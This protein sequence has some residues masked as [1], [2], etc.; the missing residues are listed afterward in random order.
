M[1]K[2]LVS[3]LTLLVCFALA[4]PA[5]AQ[6]ANTS[7]TG[8]TVPGR[9]RGLEAPEEKKEGSTTTQSGGSTSEGDG[10]TDAVGAGTRSAIPSTRNKPG[11]R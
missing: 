3:L 7:G 11:L 6:D 2:N 8:T 1:R 5:F 4:A 10:S 9:H